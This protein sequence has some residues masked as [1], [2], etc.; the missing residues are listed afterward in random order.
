MNAARIE[1]ATEASLPR[2]ADAVVVG[3]GIAGTATAFWLSRA[4]LDTVVLERRDGLGTLT[5]AASAE[6]FRAQFTEPAMMALARPSLEFFENFAE[7]TGLP[8]YSI[9]LH[10]QGYL[11]VTADPA[12]DW[13]MGS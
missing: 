7:R 6:C 1:V 8:D 13:A 3:G 11:F 5:T 10:Q 4:G 12:Q 2:T 9:G